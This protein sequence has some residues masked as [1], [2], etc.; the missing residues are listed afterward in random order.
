M[1]PLQ[2]QISLK[3]LRITQYD[4]EEVVEVV[5]N[6]TGQSTDRLHFLGLA[7]SLVRA[8]PLGDIAANA[9]DREALLA[10]VQDVHRRFYPDGATIFVSMREVKK[11]L[12]VNPRFLLHFFAA[13]SVDRLSD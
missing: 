1:V 7:K 13:F 3:Q 10:A 8:P 11:Q 9:Y 2:V 5:R 6:P 12:A 4:A